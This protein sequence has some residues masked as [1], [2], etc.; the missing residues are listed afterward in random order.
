M[1][2]RVGEKVLSPEQ[3]QALLTKVSESAEIL[4]PCSVVL[5]A[6]ERA[7]ATK[8]RPDGEWVVKTLGQIANDHGLSLPGLSVAGM[9]ADMGVADQLKP[10]AAKTAALSERVEDTILEARSECWWAAT[11][12]YTA[13]VRMADSNPEIAKAIKPVIDYFAVGKR[14]KA[15]PE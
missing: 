2:N 7:R 3:V 8:M 12:Y 5:T 13:L 10:L 4:A 15:Q 1:I 14:K 11:A 9:L 6:E